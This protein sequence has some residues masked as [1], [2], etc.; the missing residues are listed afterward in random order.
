MTTWDVWR[1]DRLPM[2]GAVC[3]IWGLTVGD[4]HAVRGDLDG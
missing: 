2:S 4:G 3:P 1:A